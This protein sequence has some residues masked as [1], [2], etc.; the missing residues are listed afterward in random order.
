MAKNTVVK[1]NRTEETV[2]RIWPRLSGFVKFDCTP[3]GGSRPGS[4]SSAAG[5]SVS[6]AF[7]GE[8]DDMTN[9]VPLLSCCSILTKVRDIS[10]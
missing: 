1:A 2:T 5:G 4:N 9:D 3:G 10:H 7:S 6:K 8:L